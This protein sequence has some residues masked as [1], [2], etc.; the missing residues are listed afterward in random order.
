MTE[1]KK[2]LNAIT[3]INSNAIYSIREV[4]D[5]TLDGVEIEWHEGT[6]PISKADIKTEMERLQNIEDNK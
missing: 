1:I 2:I 6:T 4:T 5:V 3:N